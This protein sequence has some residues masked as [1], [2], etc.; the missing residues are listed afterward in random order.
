[1]ENIT[2]MI[3]K[4]KCYGNEYMIFNNLSDED[5]EFYCEHKDE[6]IEGVLKE[7]KIDSVI[8]VYV[9]YTEKDAKADYE[10]Y[11]SER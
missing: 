11:I 3:N 2:N 8:G 10:R 1:M 4:S 5:I 6:I 7:N 9:N